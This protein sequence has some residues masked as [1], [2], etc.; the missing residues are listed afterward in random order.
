M[1]ETRVPVCLP[2]VNAGAFIGLLVFLHSQYCS[3]CPTAVATPHPTLCRVG[4][5]F[6]PVCLPGFNAG[7]F[8]HAYVACL[9]AQ[10]GVFLALLSGAGDA[11]HRLAGGKRKCVAWRRMF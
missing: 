10:Q 2:G 11:F 3:T 4:E 7:A 1:G 6:V 9:D 8:L 5:T